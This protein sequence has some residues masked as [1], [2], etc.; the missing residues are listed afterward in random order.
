MKRKRILLRILPYFISIFVGLLLYFIGLKQNENFKSLLLNIS[1]AFFAIPLIYLFYQIARNFSQKQLN[2]EIFYYAKT[3]VDPDILSILLYISK[4][5][6]GVKEG[7]DGKYWGRLFD[8]AK[9]EIAKIL[10]ER[11]F[12][13]F[14][15]LKISVETRKYFSTVLE[16][17]FIL[18]RFED[19]HIRI[20]IGLIKSL[21]KL[22]EIFLNQD[23]LN[24]LKDDKDI[25]AFK[26]IKRNEMN[27]LNE[28]LPNRYLL[29]K[30]I[31]NI[32]RAVVEDFG[33]FRENDIS[34]LL[35]YYSIQS[36][37]LDL[38]TNQIYKILDL[39]RQWIQLTD[40]KLILSDSYSTN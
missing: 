30:Q 38:V 25:S 15:I 36:D 19:K 34:R 26:V 32:G 1:A 17:N 4:L 13:G 9:K 8:I 33:D 37:I 22:E 7:R 3:Q 29:L 28:R 39:I 5:L 10:E 11:K 35:L 16:N 23:N 14:Q 2:K 6:Y 12:L 21:S 18:S 20:L 24:T 40:K 27:P 31:G